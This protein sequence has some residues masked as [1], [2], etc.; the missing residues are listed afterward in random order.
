MPRCATNQ[1]EVAQRA[2][3]RKST[4]LNSSHVAIS[5]A[6]FCLKKK[7]NEHDSGGRKLEDVYVFAIAICQATGILISK[8]FR[9]DNPDDLLAGS[10]MLAAQCASYCLSR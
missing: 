2:K 9:C 4:R 7:T 5:Y 8:S 3:D 1:R 10:L 6:V